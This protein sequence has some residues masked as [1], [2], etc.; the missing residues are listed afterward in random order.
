MPNLTPL[1]DLMA[2]LRHPDSGCPWDIRQTSQ[3]ISHYTLE[4]TYELL[5]A[6][7][8]ND[9][10]HIK[11]ELGD[12]LFHVVFHSQIAA[13][14]G[15]FDIDDVINEVVHKMTRRHPHVFDESRDNRISDEEL[16]TQWQQHKKRE[17]TNPPR[18]LDEVGHKLPAMMRAQLIQ[19]AAAGYYFDWPDATPVLDKI[20]EEISEL[21]E[22]LEGRDT[23]HI[24]S[25]MGD[26]LFACVNL[27]RHVRVDAESALRQTN[28]KFIRRFD[29]VVDQMQQAG[30][31]FSPQ[32][33]EQMESFWQQSKKVTG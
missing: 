17:K 10:D 22:A 6:I 30:I 28:E 20:E 7:E 11:E 5:H 33:L 13:E 24:Q 12:L 26:V 25:E 18:V 23:S 8:A 27:A 14:N 4:E 16:D 29:Y 19:N 31:E 3:S 32:Q 21:R 2:A 1:T 15:L 9:P